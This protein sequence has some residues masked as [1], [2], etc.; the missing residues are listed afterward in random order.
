MDTATAGDRGSRCRH[1]LRL[2]LPL[3]LSLIPFCSS[4]SQWIFNDAEGLCIRDGGRQAFK[5]AVRSGSASN[6]GCRAEY[7]AMR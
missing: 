5:T 3:P 6:A 4:R 1:C 2:Q 7:N